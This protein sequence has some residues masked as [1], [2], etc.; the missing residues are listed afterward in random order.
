MELTG[1]MLSRRFLHN[2]RHS[3]RSILSEGVQRWEIIAEEY[4]L[5]L[6]NDLLNGSGRHQRGWRGLG[7]RQDQLVCLGLE[8]N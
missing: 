7:M 2:K 4:G 6:R 3:G 8:K 5:G 1:A